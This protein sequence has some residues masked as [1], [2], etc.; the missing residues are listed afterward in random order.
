MYPADRLIYLQYVPA[1]E[2]VDAGTTAGMRP[3]ALTDL[4]ASVHDQACQLRLKS[5]DPAAIAHGLSPD[6]G[7]HRCATGLIRH[8]DFGLDGGAP[9]STEGDPDPDYFPHR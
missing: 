6:S 4:I 8:L 5:L 1:V 3:A 2:P 9:S 7:G